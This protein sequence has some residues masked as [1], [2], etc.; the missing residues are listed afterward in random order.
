M[1]LFPG[2]GYFKYITSAFSHQKAETVRKEAAALALDQP[3]PSTP[4]QEREGLESQK[5]LAEIIHTQ[6]HDLEAVPQPRSTGISGPTYTWQRVPQ[7]TLLDSR[8]AS[9]FPSHG[10]H[11]ERVEE[12]AMLTLIMDDLVNKQE[13][14]QGMKKLMLQVTER[15]C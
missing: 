13:S 12:T 6:E 15:R 2:I 1:V 11:R 9:C 3:L 10:V 14:K 7:G 4:P 5:G 8:A